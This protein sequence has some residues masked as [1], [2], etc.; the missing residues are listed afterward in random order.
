MQNICEIVMHIHIS[1]NTLK[2]FNIYSLKLIWLV[3]L[4][5]TIGIFQDGFQ[6]KMAFCRAI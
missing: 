5:L 3:P 4:N 2:Q 1:W 6:G